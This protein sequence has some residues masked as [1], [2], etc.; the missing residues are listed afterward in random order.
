[1][2]VDG[3]SLLMPILLRLGTLSG[4]TLFIDV[5][6]KGLTLRIGEE[7]VNLQGRVELDALLAKLAYAR[8]L[9]PEVP[10]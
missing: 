8:S 6:Q 3:D 1:M 4:R 5:G 10:L 7:W 2:G 9:L